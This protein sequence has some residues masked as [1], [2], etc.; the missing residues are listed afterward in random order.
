MNIVIAG[1]GEVGSHAAEVLSKDGHNITVIDLD[2]D[3]VERLSDALD[4]KTLVGHCAHYQVLNDAGIE[5]ADLFIAATQVDEINLL[6]AFMAKT[7]GAKKTIA[8]V[9]HT[10]NFS[11]RGTKYAADLGIDELICPE[12]STSMAIARTL[13]NPGSIELEEFGRGQLLMQEIP[14]TEA[15]SA[16]GQA[17]ADL[18][19]PAGA[20]VATVERD[21]EVAIARADTMIEPGDLVT[22]IGDAKTFDSARKLFSRGK[23]KR[24]QVAVMG[25]TS[26]AV[27]LC[28]ALKNRSFSVRLFVEHRARAEELSEKLEH[29]TILESDPTDASVIADEHLEKADVFIAVTQDDEH[30]I[31]S[32]AQAKTLGL[33]SV[34]A[35]VQSSKYLHLLS[36]VGIDRVFS[37][38]AVA[39]KAIER[40]IHTGGPRLVASFAEGVAEVYEVHPGKKC[41]ILGHELRNIKLPPG[42]MIAALRRSDKSFVPGADDQLAIGDT[43]LVIGPS[44][45]KAEL[46]ELFSAI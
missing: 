4:V 31:L 42:S 12:Y 35:V 46:Q 8:R 6:S 37:P 18:T 38:R 2:A 32:C 11:L 44:G 41:D 14:V 10:A 9:H 1:T 25:E 36:H 29:V 7:A 43:I 19:L 16:A 45:C 20:R 3:R 15:A 26:T 22:L 13:R 34:I 27:W 39:V 40:L 33:Q 23:E 30:N 21:D 28:R 24:M 17:L 5:H